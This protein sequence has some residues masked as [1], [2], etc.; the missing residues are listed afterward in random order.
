[1][2][3]PESHATDLFEGLPIADLRCAGS[4]AWDVDAI[5]RAL[6]ARPEV[7]AH[8]ISHQAH[9]VVHGAEPVAP[10]SVL[11]AIANVIGMLR[12]TFA[13]DPQAIHAWLNAPN[14]LLGGRQPRET[15]LTP[16]GARGVEQLA[17]GGWLGEP[18]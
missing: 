12:H 18:T 4:D 11:S 17:A 2:P 14:A 15:L 1:M 9:A 10:Q 6:A 16:G 3:Q 8:A 13:G 7:L 5:A